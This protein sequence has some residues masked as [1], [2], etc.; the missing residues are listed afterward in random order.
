M[1][2]QLFAQE[3]TE[4]ATPKRREEARN[5]GQIAKSVE[6]V[7]AS[8]LLGSYM[9]LRM[10][11]PTMA[12][13]VLSFARNLW[14]QGPQQDWSEAGVHML[15]INLFLA[16]AVVVAPVLAA[17]AVA[18][19]VSNLLQV[20]FLFTLQPLTPSFD[21]LNPIAGLKRVFSRR[22]LAEMAKSILKIGIIGYV[23]YSTVSGD[24]DSFPVLLGL[25][26]PQVVTFLTDLVSRLML[27]V[28]LAM[29][30]LA[31]ADYFY[32]RW[33][34][35]QSLRMSKQELKEEFKQQDGNPEIRSKIRQKQREL[36]RGRMME[37]VKKADV[38]VTNPTHYAVALAYQ[39]DSMAA[40]T[41]L[42]KGQGL[43]A[44]R[45]RELAQEN[46]IPIV[47]NKPLARELHRVVDVGQA[48]PAD[49]YQAVAEVLAFVYQL[50]QKGY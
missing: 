13:R 31:L 18:G 48:V 36:A 10:M 46:A 39:S 14:E 35:E 33:E 26:M 37:D 27:R 9:L 1:Y 41:V 17:T 23:A 42:A 21:R 22:A 29:L 6:L 32:Q 49:L 8:S 28:G 20:G 38:I 25:E 5:K 40:P 24:L 3:R 11:G 4:E 7:A 47:E 2:L 43:I 34:Y 16:A 45:I 30:V 15:L 12:G 19:V 44:L 50:K